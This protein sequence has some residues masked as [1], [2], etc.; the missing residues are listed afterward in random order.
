VDSLDRGFS[1]VP[2]GAWPTAFSE[3]EKWLRGLWLRA[4][5][6]G[7]HL[8]LSLEGPSPSCGY[9]LPGGAQANQRSADLTAVANLFRL[10]L[11][12]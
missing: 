10:V 4:S 6:L 11:G 1:P 12:G 7:S 3:R 8:R 5:A 9:V 2:G